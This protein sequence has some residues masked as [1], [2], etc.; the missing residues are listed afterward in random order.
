MPKTLNIIFLTV[1]VQAC[2]HHYFTVAIKHLGMKS[3]I[4]RLVFVCVV[5]VKKRQ[6]FCKLEKTLLILFYVIHVIYKRLYCCS[7]KVFFC[8]NPLQNQTI[9]P[10]KW[11]LF[12]I[13]PSTQSPVTILNY[14]HFKVY[15][16]LRYFL[17]TQ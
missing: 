16:Q 5:I 17:F 12:S 14:F 2:K 15:L 13:L 7:L 11:N 6:C 8:N 4:D 1:L 10:F 9:Y 3:D